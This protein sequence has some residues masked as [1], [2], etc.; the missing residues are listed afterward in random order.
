MS[1]WAFAHVIVPVTT[2]QPVWKQDCQQATLTTLQI[3]RAHTVLYATGN[4]E[5]KPGVQGYHAKCQS[6]GQQHRGPNWAIQEA[7]RSLCLPALRGLLAWQPHRWAWPCLGSTCGHISVRHCHSHPKLSSQCYLSNFWNIFISLAVGVF[8]RSS[9]A[10]WKME[11]FVNGTE[12]IHSVNGHSSLPF[13]C[14]DGTSSQDYWPNFYDRSPTICF[15]GAFKWL[16]RLT[17]LN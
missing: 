16:Y 3:N 6:K 9:S 1:Q 15:S 2:W 7:H 5:R 13:R 17:M 12:Y 4:S 8:M 10:F 14:P 11:A